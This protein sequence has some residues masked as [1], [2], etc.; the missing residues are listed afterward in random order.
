MNV[1]RG[2]F[3]ETSKK[4]KK[5][6]QAGSCTYVCQDKFLIQQ[7]FNVD[8]IM[9]HIAIQCITFGQPQIFFSFWKSLRPKSL[10]WFSSYLGQPQSCTYV[11]PAVAAPLV[12]VTQNW[13]TADFQCSTNPDGIHGV[14]A[15]AS[16]ASSASCGCSGC[17]CRECVYI[18]FI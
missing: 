6:R 12:H 10:V 11:N 13:T 15:R 17:A 1:Q 16:Y 9:D 5:K 3:G 4:K 8:F 14:W 18:M 7:S 2:G